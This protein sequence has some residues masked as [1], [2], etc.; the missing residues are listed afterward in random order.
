MTWAWLHPEKFNMG[1]GRI[2][3]RSG[4]TW[5]LYISLQNLPIYK[6][7]SSLILGTC[8][9]T[10]SHAGILSQRVSPYF[11]F[12]IF[13]FCVVDDFWMQKCASHRSHQNNSCIIMKHSTFFSTSE[14]PNCR[15]VMYWWTT[16]PFL[17][18]NWKKKQ[19]KSSR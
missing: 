12:R 19:R 5:D 4:G 16:Y 1:A 7:T 10:M 3:F 13:F 11:F 2:T 15:L 8:L 9:L 17:Y 18:V 6:S 14:S